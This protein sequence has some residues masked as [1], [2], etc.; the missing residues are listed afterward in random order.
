MRP[1]ILG[2]MMASIIG[3]TAL[4]GTSPIHA[5]ADTFTASIQTPIDFREF[6]PCALDGQGEYVRLTGELHFVFHV[7]MGKGGNFH[8]VDEVNPQGVIGTGEVS[9]DTYQ[10][11]GMGQ[12]IYNGAAFPFEKTL[13]ENFRIIGQGPD[14]NLLV[15]ETRHITINANGDVKATVENFSIECN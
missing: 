15:H 1:L 5:Q 3:L 12:S 6:V 8:I 10:G 11:T 7:T 13:V 14:N 2:L 9:G 4:A